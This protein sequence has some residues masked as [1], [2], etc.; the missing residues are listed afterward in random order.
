MLFV[1]VGEDQ[2]QHVE[3][4]RDIAMKFNFRYSDTFTI[5]EPIIPKTGARIMDLQN[6]LSKMGKSDSGESGRI[7]LIDDPS[8]VSKRIRS[9]VT[10]SGSEI[11]YSESEEKA[12]IRNL[13]T[14]YSNLTDKSIPEIEKLYEGKGYG[15]FKKDLAD[16][17][18]QKLRPIKEKHDD[19]MRNKDY[20]ESVLKT[21][22]ENAQKKA[23]KVLSK[24]YRKVG[25]VQT[26]RL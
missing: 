17:V 14:I 11:R 24:V 20:L 15:D 12:G 2:K 5:P 10:D 23:W 1:P 4:T 8:V 25:L 21:G 3:L 22:A 7:A 6:P 9:A 18:V 16:I 19:L 26:G 13:L